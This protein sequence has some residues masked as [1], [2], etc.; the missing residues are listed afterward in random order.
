[1]TSS[2]ISKGERLTFSSKS[3]SPSKHASAPDIE[4]VDG[5]NG[6][7]HRSASMEYRT[8]S[9][10]K[11]SQNALLD[12]G[13]RLVQ[14]SSIS[15]TTRLAHSQELEVRPRGRTRNR[16]WKPIKFYGFPDAR[17]ER[18]V[19]D[20]AGF[21]ASDL[22]ARELE[23]TYLTNLRLSWPACELILEDEYCLATASSLADTGPS[24]RTCRIMPC[25]AVH[26]K[27]WGVERSPCDATGLRV[28]TVLWST[29]LPIGSEGTWTRFA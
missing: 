8:A 21:L 20:M 23:D 17:F 4:A 2:A 13:M 28:R 5:Q 1:M 19:T 24:G 9:A 11:E 10:M 7:R 25:L 27:D 18:S 16:P 15:R 26:G 22:R 29:K 14:P 12:L 6:T 3:T